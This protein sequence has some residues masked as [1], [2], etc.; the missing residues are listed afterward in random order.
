M[1]A[2]QLAQRQSLPLEAK[3]IL[4]SRAIRQWYE[5]WE[6]QVYVSFSGGLDSTALL[7]LVRSI[8]PNVPAVFVD[9]GVEYPEV[10]NFVKTVNNVIWLKPKMQFAGVIKTYGYPVVSKENSQKI[11]EAVNTKSNKLRDLRLTGGPENKRGKIPKKWLYLVD[12]PFKISHKCCDVLKK[13]PIKQFEK[14]TKL[15]AFIGEMAADSSLRLMK[16]L[17]NG[18]CNAFSSGTPA[19]RPLS[20]WLKSDVVS[21]IKNT[22]VSY[23]SIYDM[24]YD[25][26]GC[27]YCAF[28]CDQNETNKFQLLKQTHPKLHKYC[29]DKLGMRLVL[30]YLGVDYE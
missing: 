25:R 30:N 27:V 6:G 14:T 22:G 16:Y 10:R 2:W 12:A 15:H 21:Y 20:V 29:L 4:A 26:T 23:S 13:N 18:G 5:H 17:K 8:Y 1:E 19:S 24:G 7:H 9:T 28:G 3:I 11:Y